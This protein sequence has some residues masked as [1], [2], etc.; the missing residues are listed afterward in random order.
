MGL[1]D[2]D[3]NHGEDKKEKQESNEPPEPG[4]SMWNRLGFG[5][6]EFAFDILVVIKLLFF[7]E[8][9]AGGV[10]SFRPAGLLA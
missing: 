4:Y 5:G 10:G 7:G 6:A 3:E 2:F 1:T 9:E 8:V